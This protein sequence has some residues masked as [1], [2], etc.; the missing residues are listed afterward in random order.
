EEHAIPLG[1]ALAHDP[2]PHARRLLPVQVA[3]IVARRELPQ[4]PDV[5]AAAALARMGPAADPRVLGRD[6]RNGD[7]LR[8]WIHDDL[9]R[10]ARPPIL[11]EEAEREP[12]Q[13]SGIRLEEDAPP[14][15]DALDDHFPLLPGAERIHPQRTREGLVEEEER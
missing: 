4:R 8:Q 7:R 14:R 10:E 3:R 12:R 13:H 9:A 11:P 5:R 2:A 1:L 6:L 15:K